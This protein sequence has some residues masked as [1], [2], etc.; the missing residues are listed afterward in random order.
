MK[1]LLIS[2]LFPPQ[3]VGGYEVLAYQMT[4]QLRAQ[5]HDVYVLTSNEVIRP[6]FVRERVPHVHPRLRIVE[7]T[8]SDN[9]GDYRFQAHVWQ[10]FNNEEL[11]RV[12]EEFTPDVAY[13]WN[14]EG[15]GSFGL[16]HTLA[17]HGLPIIWHLQDSVP[18]KAIEA[19]GVH[20]SLVSEFFASEKLL[21]IITVSKT[22]TEEITSYGTR[23]VH[24]IT[25]IRN[26]ILPHATDR[27][28]FWTPDSTQPLRILFAGQLA[29]HKGLDFAVDALSALHKSGLTNFTF[30]L[31]GNQT[32]H[33]ESALQRAE[34]NGWSENFYFDGPKTMA[35][36]SETYLKHDLFLFPTW[37]RDPMPIVVLESASFGC[38]PMLSENCGTAEWVEDN[39]D[40]ILVKR[41]VSAL[42][43]ALTRVMTEPDY[44]RNIAQYGLSNMQ[45]HF[46]IDEPLRLVTSLLLSQETTEK[47]DFYAST[48]ALEAKLFQRAAGT[49]QQSLAAQRVVKRALSG[50]K[51]KFVIWVDGLPWVRDISGT[52][53]RN[54]EKFGKS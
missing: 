44:L 17:T 28:F 26:W 41:D 35:Q 39:Q 23:F 21:R 38:V 12:I 10:R 33:I 13:V 15:L 8:L 5:G 3:I 45:S 27:S 34:E 31:V 43:A 6:E 29:P 53:A 19:A 2:N 46:S 1:I 7:P 40:A 4:D 18:Y 52:R 47:K 54:R 37:S 16:I 48:R 20:S 32:K 51:L 42:R 30:T 50:A 14:T 49:S 36:M 25:E 22:L 9:S 11:H 24:P